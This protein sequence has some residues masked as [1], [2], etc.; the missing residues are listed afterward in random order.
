M[1]SIQNVRAVGNPQRAYEWEF[2]ILG[3]S[4]SGS[5]PILM[6]RVQTVNIP[7]KSN[8]TITI[9]YKSQPAR[10]AGR[11]SS[12]GTFTV[13]FW[14]TEEHEVYSM[15]N[16]WHENG[17]TN[18]VVGGGVTKDLYAV[19]AIVEYKA[20]DSQATTGTHRFNS[21]FVQSIGDISLDYSSSEHKTFTVTFSYDR[22]MFDPA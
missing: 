4:I 15:F 12:P 16:D 17:I 18:S 11:D 20:H 3:S 14:D 2:Q 9:N 1:S 19:D 7:E 6:E 5:L 22:H 10:Y 13:T 21:V 8:E